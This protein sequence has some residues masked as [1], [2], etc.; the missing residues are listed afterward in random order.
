MTPKLNWELN[1]GQSCGLIMVKIET[2]TVRHDIHFG[3][4]FGVF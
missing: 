1:Y 2:T 4:A 3:V